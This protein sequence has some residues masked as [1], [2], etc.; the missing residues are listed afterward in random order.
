MEDPA[1]QLLRC[2]V[3]EAR[4]PAWPWVIKGSAAPTPTVLVEAD[5]WQN[6]APAHSS[7]PRLKTS[8]LLHW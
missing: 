3:E 8:P 7:A 6:P 5:L 1:A 2:P 4:N